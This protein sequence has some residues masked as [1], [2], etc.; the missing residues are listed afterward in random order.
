MKNNLGNPQTAEQVIARAQR[1]QPSSQPL[2]G[3]MTVTEMLHHC[4][5]V[6]HQLLSPASSSAKKTSLKQYLL[7]WLVLYGMPRFP[8]NAQT[9]KAMRTKGTIDNAEFEK[10]REEFVASVKKFATNTEPI[11]HFH[12]YFGKLSTKQWGITSWKHVDHH[13]R[14]FGV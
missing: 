5:K 11:A 6:H 12:P 10:Q 8:R 1:L 4:N 13:L 2:W 3:T 9:P 7:R 14:Q